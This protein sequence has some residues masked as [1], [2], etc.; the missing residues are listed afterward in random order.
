MNELSSAVSHVPKTATGFRG[1]DAMTGGGL[2][3]GRITVIGGGPGTGKTLFALQ[4]MVHNIRH[5]NRPGVFVSFEESPDSIV[6]NFSGFGWELKDL[7]ADSLFLVD[8][9]WQPETLQ[10]GDF[11]IA[12][13]LAAVEGIVKQQDSAYLVLDGIDALFALL[14][15]QR[16]CRRELIRLQTWAERLALTT[17]VTIKTPGT[18]LHHTTAPWAGQFEDIATFLADCVIALER[19][20]VEGMSHRSLYIQKYRGSSHTQNKVPYIIDANGIEVEPVDT[21]A[22]GFKV[23][24]ERLSTGIPDLDDMLHGGYYRGSTTLITGSPGT[25]KTTLASKFAETACDRGEKGVYMCFDEAPEEIVRNVRSVNITLSGHIK[26]GLLHMEGL[27][28]RSSSPDILASRVRNLL[29]RLQPRFLVLDPVSAFGNVGGD[30]LAYDAVRLIIHQ[31]KHQGVTVVL[32]SLLEHLGENAEMSKAHVSTLADN[33]LHLNYVIRGGERNRSLTIVKSRGTGHS[34]QVRELVLSNQGV[35]LEP[36][37]V[38]EGEVLMGALRWQQEEKNR[39]ES[40]RAQLEAERHALDNA[41]DIDDIASRIRQLEQQLEIKR[42]D[43]EQ[44]ELEAAE[45]TFEERNRREKLSE[46]RTPGQSRKTGQRKTASSP[47]KQRQK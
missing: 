32:T 31:C 8:G 11:D 7:L 12:G 28:A 38:E 37:Y 43:A 18:L 42:R 4:A 17:L 6:R 27:V 25:S 30:D 40:R 45:S 9:R 5:R 10:S 41:R 47:S 35:H 19:N 3:Q 2:P 13:L 44:I 36:V 16:D 34:N 33:W 24:K 1:F 22:G 14:P 29:T 46:I 15:D 23:Y 21:R 39:R 26:S 20:T